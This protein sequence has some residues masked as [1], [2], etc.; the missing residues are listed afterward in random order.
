MRDIGDGVFCVTVGLVGW[1]AMASAGALPEGRPA[2]RKKRGAESLAPTFCFPARRFFAGAPA[3]ALAFGEGAASRRRKSKAKS[4]RTSKGRLFLC[5]PLGFAF[6][7]SPREGGAHSFSS[8]KVFAGAP[9]Q[10]GFPFPQGGACALGVLG[11]VLTLL[12]Y[13]TGRFKRRVS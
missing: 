8:R 5:A 2:G 13:Y 3:P 7:F 1:S 4:I 11:L 10:R 12:F 6:D 9:H